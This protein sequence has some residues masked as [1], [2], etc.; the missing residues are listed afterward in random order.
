MKIYPGREFVCSE[1]KFAIFCHTSILVQSAKKRK[2]N[3][4]HK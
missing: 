2:H 4:K 3:E 1:N